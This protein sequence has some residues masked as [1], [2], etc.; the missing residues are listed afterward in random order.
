[1]STIA[2]TFIIPPRP[3]GDPNKYDAETIKQ[4]LVLLS[5]PKIGE[6]TFINN[7]VE[8]FSADEGKW[9]PFKLWNV[10]VAPEYDNQVDVAYK[11]I[12]YN[13]VICSKSRQQGITT[14]VL[15]HFLYHLL[16]K[17]IEQILLLSRGQL[18]SIEQMRRLRGSY[19]RLPYWLRVKDEPTVS[20][21]YWSLSNGSSV[22][23]LSTNSGDG[24]SA[25]RILVDEADLI[26]Q[27]GGSLRETLLK[28]SPVVG[29]KGQLILVSK[30]E[31]TR[32]NST[33]KNIF[34]ESLEGK[35]N[36][37]T[38][39]V[40][41]DAH[42]D[43]TLDW[44]EERKR[45]SLAATGT[46]DDLFENFPATISEMLSPKSTDKRLPYVWIEQCYQPEKPLTPEQ[47]KNLTEPGW[48]E[49]HKDV[50]GIPRV[51]FYRM[52]RPGH[53]FVLSVDVAEGAQ[54]SD[55]SS[56]HVLN[57]ETQEESCRIAGKLEPSTLGYYADLI[58]HFYNEAKVFPERNAHG[59]AF[60]LWMREFSQL[61]VLVGPDGKP[62]FSTTPSTKST[63]YSKVADSLRDK[64]TI[65][66]SA[67][68]FKQLSIVRESDLSAPKGDHDDVAVT[69]MLAI[70]AITMILNKTFS[71]EFI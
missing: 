60:L 1:M 22:L 51:E 44:Y 46:L 66:H 70:Y 34:R 14:L 25:R 39:F 48:Y 41:W 3:P 45:E 71:L 63:G 12:N 55:D 32:P 8:I 47:Q 4:Q 5:D 43:R 64:K 15:A 30:V 38:C 10:P 23:S 11:L 36:F 27:S 53:Q 7:Y 20:K 57:V 40:P 2:R 42:G 37:Q 59:H 24:F 49:K 68:T 35:T 67:E 6:L 54:S 31:K 13:R 26:W 18:E 16:F 29:T 58:G 21:T 33:F 69:F 17:P 9:I 52:P 19:N 28:V 56:I 62:G 61:R 50:F 65:I